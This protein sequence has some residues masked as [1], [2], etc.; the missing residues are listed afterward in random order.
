MPNFILN[1]LKVFSAP[2]IW[3]QLIHLIFGSLGVYVLLRFLKLDFMPALFGSILFLMTPY[4]NVCIV[5][6]HGSQI[7][8]AAYIPWI[9][10]GLFKIWDKQNLQNLGILA[11]LIGFQLQ[12]GH[13]QIAY[14]TWLMIAIFV[15]YTIIIE[16]IT[17]I[18]KNSIKRPK[19]SSNFYI[20]LVGSLFF[21]FLM[22]VSI[23]WPSYLY[24][25]H[26]IRSAVQGGSG[27]DYA[28]MWS[29][30]IK[31]MITFIIPSFYGFGGATY[32][33]TIEPSMTDF[34]NYLGIF[35]IIFIIYGILKRLKNND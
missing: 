5:H 33:G 8:T 9:C 25:E 15:L 26:S 17:S 1:I 28:T 11:I 19:F 4:M 22:S 16:V 27:I 13:I 18:F 20:Y 29:F 32:W 6:G 21:G 10:W 3:T 12:R 23:V 31:E 30:T 2:E 7:M 35:T 24:S 34:P 14:Y